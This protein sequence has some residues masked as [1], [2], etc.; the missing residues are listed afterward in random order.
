[1]STHIPTLRQLQYLIAVAEEGHFGRAAQRCFVTQSTLSAGIQELESILGVTVIE[2]TKRRVVVTPLG[3]EL[4]ARARRVLAEVE[5]M[6]VTAK[7]STRPLTGLLRLGAIP[8]IGPYVLPKVLPP[9]RASYPELRLFLR[10]DR[11]ARLVDQLVGGDLDA[12]LIALPYDT[13]D[14]EDMV[15][16]DDPFWLALPPDHPLAGGNGPVAADLVDTEDLLL[17]EDGHCL[18]DHALAA[19]RRQPAPG[20]SGA[21]QATSLYTLV[22]LVAGGFG[23]TLLPDVAL[24]SDHVRT[25]D[26]ALRPL[27]GGAGRQIALAWRRNSARRSEYKLLGQF[28]KNQLYPGI[29]R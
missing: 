20:R 7:A 26:V 2:R 11:T 22:E 13:A 21:F 3:L 9:L 19:C 4:V 10:E 15:L 6:T 18:R 29:G 12:A 5:D 16:A 24:K 1:M 25:A 14:L 23:T 8:T 28:L 27:S 17:L